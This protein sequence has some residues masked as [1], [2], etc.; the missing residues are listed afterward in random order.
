MARK[1]CNSEPI[2]T[3]RRIPRVKS[4]CAR[5][6][7]R[8]SRRGTLDKV[9]V[10]M[11]A[12]RG[13]LFEHKIRCLGFSGADGDFLCLSAEFFVPCLDRIGPGWKTLEIEIPVL[14]CDCKVRMLED[15]NVS[16]HPR[17]HVAL[18]W[19]RNLFP[20]EGLLDRHAVGL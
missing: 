8:T 7:G 6:T 9:A 3:S 5:S 12:P 15:R 17:V 19:N 4:A 16:P 18:H 13:L 14:I 20:R 1:H 2:S 10:S 11:A